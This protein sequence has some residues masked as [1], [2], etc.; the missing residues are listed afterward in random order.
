MATRKE[1]GR[2]REER[3][4]SKKDKSLESKK[5]ESLREQGGAK[6]PVL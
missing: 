3:L 1:G 5:S 6:Q 2:E 4:E